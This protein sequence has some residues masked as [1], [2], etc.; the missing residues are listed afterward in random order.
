MNTEKINLIIAQ[1]LFKEALAKIAQKEKERIYCRHDLEHLL[2]VARLGYIINSEENL[3]LDPTLIYAAALLHDL[4]KSADG[5]DHAQKS[6]ELAQIILPACGFSEA[7]LKEIV[8]AI[9]SHRRLSSQ[10]DLSY[11]L[12]QADKKS[13][14][15]FLC[16]VAS[17]CNWPAEKK[18]SQLW[19]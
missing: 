6:A 10:G 18:N 16:P 9:A 5:G 2:A 4:G 13:R 19:R 8:C 11:L 15:C 14:S 1:P 17:S 7:E 3:N 12:Y